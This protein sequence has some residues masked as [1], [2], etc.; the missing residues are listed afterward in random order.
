M[1]HYP[2]KLIGPYLNYEVL[3]KLGKGCSIASLKAGWGRL[4]MKPHKPKNRDKTRVKKKGGNEGCK[5]KTSIVSKYSDS[6]LA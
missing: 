6:K 2:T 1:L 4:E 3:H 5:S